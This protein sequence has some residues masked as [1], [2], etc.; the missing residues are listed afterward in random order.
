[1]NRYV[2]LVLLLLVPL[3]LIAAVALSIY[4]LAGPSDNDKSANT[5][6]YLVGMV[7]GVY[8]VVIITWFIYK[9]KRE[10]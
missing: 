4:G 6:G 7:Y 5:I 3:A 10:L 9:N 2:Q 8:A 1:M